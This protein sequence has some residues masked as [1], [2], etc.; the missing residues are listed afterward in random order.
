MLE[1][2][3]QFLD[4]LSDAHD[5]RATVAATA[6]PVAA[7]SIW[8]YSIAAILK[9]VLAK[10]RELGKE[11]RPEIEKAAKDAIDR[12]VALDLPWVP[13]NLEGVIDAATKSL[14]YAA[15]D[16]ILDA[17]FAEQVQP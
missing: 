6:V 9:L 2:N 11:Y 10:A 4:A 13:E 17:L 7:I 15:I 1:L 5:E 16:A 3:E 8:G 14:G 12:L